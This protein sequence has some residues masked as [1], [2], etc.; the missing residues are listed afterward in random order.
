MPSCTS[1]GARVRN[2][3]IVLLLFPCN[4]LQCDLWFC[5]DLRG[6]AATLMRREIRGRLCSRRAPESN[7]LAF[8][9]ASSCLCLKHGQFTDTLHQN[10]AR[11]KGKLLKNM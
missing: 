6:Y 2:L 11:E 5:V 9:F 7:W 8:F 3:L 1:S 10:A 4:Y